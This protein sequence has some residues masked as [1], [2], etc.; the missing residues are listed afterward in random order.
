MHRME[1][2]LASAWRCPNSTTSWCLLGIA[3]LPSE[4]VRPSDSQI[5]LTIVIGLCSSRECDELLDARRRLAR[6]RRGTAVHPSG[7]C[8]TASFSRPVT[9]FLIKSLK[10]L[11]CISSFATDERI[12]VSGPW[13]LWQHSAAAPKGVMMSTV[14]PAACSKSQIHHVFG[15]QSH[16]CCFRSPR[17]IK[18]CM[19]T[20]A[21]GS[22][23][24]DHTNCDT[25]MIRR[26]Q[27]AEVLRRDFLSAIAAY[28]LWA[29]AGPSAAAS[30]PTVCERAAIPLTSLTKAGWQPLAE[31]IM[32]KEQVKAPAF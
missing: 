17:R 32:G 26:R 27:Q 23:R 12:N 28:M 14:L 5:S 9:D 20:A 1:A 4:V 18:N 19:A 29:S 11:P 22:H 15:N 6:W 16:N 2:R 21:L 13:L 25:S 3:P 30:L 8:G 10:L 24:Q 7:S 31:R